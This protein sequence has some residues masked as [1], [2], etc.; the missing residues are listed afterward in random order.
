MDPNQDR[1]PF[2]AMTIVGSQ[3]RREDV[4][5]KAILGDA[6]WTCKRAE[7]GN[8]RACI[9]IRRCVQR[10][11]PWLNGLRRPPTQVAYR[12][13]GVGD[14]QEYVHP[15]VGEPANRAL[16]RVDDRAAAAIPLSMIPVS[17][18]HGGCESSYSEIMTVKTS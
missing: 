18:H 2:P 16:F 8:L 5:I 14:S 1:I 6:R 4:E 7:L 13:S 17:S 10:I 15:L 9:R 11:A 3:F 12:R